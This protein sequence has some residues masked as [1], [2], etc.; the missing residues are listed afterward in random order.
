MMVSASAEFIE[1]CLL[2]PWPGNVRELLAEAK[3]AAVAAVAAKRAYISAADLDEEAGR[4]LDASGEPQGETRGGTTVTE[5]IDIEA[6][7]K[8]EQG[9]VARAA[10]RLGVARSRVRRFIERHGIDVKALKSG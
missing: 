4:P 6:A 2:R 10:A 5:P 3:T 7:L 1:A 8:A 9:N